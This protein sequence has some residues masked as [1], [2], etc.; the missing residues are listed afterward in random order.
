MSGVPGQR[1]R[2]LR[3]SEVEWSQELEDPRQAR[4]K[5]YEHHGLLGL[6]VAAFACG[7][8]S[9]RRVEEL[10][11]D[12]GAR[13]RNR[14]SVPP[15]VSDTTLWRLLAGQST[16]GMRQTV[17][18]QVQRLLNHPGLQRVALPM[19]VMSFDGKS[20]WTSQQQP[21]AG[22]EAVAN[23]EAG[24]L[25]WRLGT[26]RAVLTSVVAAPCVDLEF[27]GAKEG[28]SPAFRQLLPRVVETWGEHFQVITA[29]AGLT[30]AEN[31]SLVRSL[32]KHYLFGL[33]GNQPTLH[34]HAI[35]SIADK[36]CAP[37]ARTEDRAHGQSVVRELW[38][39]ALKPGEVNFEG[40]RLLLCVRQTHLKDDGT[41]SIEW[42]YFVTSLSTMDLSFAHL[43]RLVRLHWAI[44]NRHHWTLDMVLEEDDRQPCLHSRSSLEVT[45]WLRVLAYNLLSA[46]RARLPLKDRLPVAW[47]RACELL[48]DALVHGRAEVPLPTLA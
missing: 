3:F 46:W 17:A 25:L 44:E 36:R 13:V 47:A 42:R 19:G 43:L 34:G 41:R 1:R 31:A 4:G 45:A 18:A 24:T 23:D 16:T 40:G 37:R 15:K 29:D 20:L 33:K 48:R 11:T 35:E 6:L 28:E 10:A 12:L 14:L 21:V 39:H 32:G 27:I 2:A 22:L 8:K 5:R 26:L 7:L 30:A 38:T 9:L